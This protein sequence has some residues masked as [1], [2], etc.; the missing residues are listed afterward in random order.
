MIESWLKQTAYK[1]T[2]SESTSSIGSVIPSD[3]KG[4]SFACLLVQNN[5]TR[6]QN[7]KNT[8]GKVETV[9]QYKLYC[10]PGNTLTEK[11]R[12]EVEGVAYEIKGKK[13][14]M[15]MNRFLVFYLEK[16]T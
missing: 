16:T 4:S 15:S 1:I 8:H 11:D 2:V 13:N 5:Q 3:A 14:P 9:I 10:Q 6:D 7:E 12:I